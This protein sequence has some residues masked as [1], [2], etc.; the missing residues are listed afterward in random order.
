MMRRYVADHPPTIPRD[1]WDNA[2]IPGEA[3]LW[4]AVIRQAIL[5]VDW[6]WLEDDGKFFARRFFLVSS[7]QW[8]EYLA[9]LANATTRPAPCDQRG[10]NHRTKKRRRIA[11]SLPAGP[12]ES[13]QENT[14]AT[15]P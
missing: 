10:G 4:W 13:P 5:D 7:E 9:A 3:R 15:I 8:R 12:R 2:Q 14:D 6:G 11:G 1:R